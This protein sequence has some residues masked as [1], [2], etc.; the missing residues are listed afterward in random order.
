M[1][2]E[3]TAPTAT[4]RPPSP[5]PRRRSAFTQRLVKSEGSG[6]PPNVL[7]D[8]RRAILLGDEPPGT[9]IPIDD[10]ARFF[11]V[12]HIPVREALKMLLS[13]G[14][15]AHVPHVGYSVAQLTFAEFRELYQVRHA[16]EM[17][18]LRAALPHANLLD[19]ARARTAFEAQLSALDVGD[20]R[21]YNI[22]SREFHMA[23]IA[24][25]RMRRLVHMYEGAWNMTEPA[26]PMAR[27]DDARR[28]DLTCDHERLLAAFVARDAELLLAESARHYAHLEEAIG[29]FSADLSIFRD[30]NS[31]HART[32]TRTDADISDT[33]ADIIPVAQA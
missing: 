2:N 24:P 10:V 23:L 8:L 1:S 30:E 21:L 3:H 4:V 15:V 13:E 5:A 11:G 19:D 32:P 16:L 9:I 6:E 18:A 20:D 28:H 26:R 17:A 25:S 33:D 22:H 14:L 29:A 27:V 31:T 12:S 7:G